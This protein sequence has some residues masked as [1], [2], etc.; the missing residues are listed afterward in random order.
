MKINEGNSYITLKADEVGM[1]PSELEPAWN[2]AIS[3]QKIE[4]PELSD[5][6]PMF[7]RK[8]MDKFDQ[9]VND[10]YIQK[11][12]SMVMAR[13]NAIQHGQEWLNS[14]A[15]SNYVR[16]NEYF[17]KFTKA[18]YESLVN[19]KGKEFMAK[20]AEKLKKSSSES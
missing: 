17:P 6:D 7:T 18:A 9:R 16:A 1:K 8:V 5:K 20:F 3:Q 13:E 15:Q 2:D 19:S 12:R 11:A 10:F 4:T 14:L